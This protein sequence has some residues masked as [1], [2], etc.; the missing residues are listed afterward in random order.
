LQANDLVPH[1]SINH[2]FLSGCVIT[3]KKPGPNVVFADLFH[4]PPRSYITG[5]VNSL[6]T[7]NILGSQTQFLCTGAF[8]YGR[9]SLLLISNKFVMR[10]GGSAVILLYR[11]GRVGEQCGKVT[12]PHLVYHTCVSDQ[13]LE[14]NRYSTTRTLLLHGGPLCILQNKKRSN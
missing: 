6:K 14:I 9:Y 1:S 3:L 8:L 5:R 7:V 10:G 4:P 13:L 12:L 2:S 11:T